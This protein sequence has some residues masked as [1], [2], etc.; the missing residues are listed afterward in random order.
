[1]QLRDRV[2]KYQRVWQALVKYLRSQCGEKARCV[3]FPLLGKFM[4]LGEQF[5]YV[6]SLEFVDSGK[7][8]FP[9]NDYNM[10]PFNK[11]L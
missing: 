10:S 8:S 4:K 5:M 6:P 2:R 1:M 11:S 3:D 7:F 9:E